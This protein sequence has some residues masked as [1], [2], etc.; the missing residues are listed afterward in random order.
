LKR[1][2]VAQDGY[3]KRYIDVNIDAA[4]AEGSFNRQR[5]ELACSAL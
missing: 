1:W 5:S 4:V 2:R 3:F